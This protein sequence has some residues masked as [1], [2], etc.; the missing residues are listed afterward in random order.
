MPQQPRATITG[1]MRLWGSRTPGE[2]NG[3][4][5]E[6]VLV[7]VVVESCVFLFWTLEVFCGFLLPV[8]CRRLL[9]FDITITSP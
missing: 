2:I 5:R 8:S 4:L 1:K 9:T 6:A 7:A 3:R